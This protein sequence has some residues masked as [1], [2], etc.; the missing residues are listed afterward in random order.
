M[1]LP[2]RLPLARI[3]I[4]RTESQDWIHDVRRR[5]PLRLCEPERL[6]HL[7]KWPIVLHVTN[8]GRSKPLFCGETT[9][10]S[11]QSLW[12]NRERALPFA[13]NCVRR[14][15]VN[16]GKRQPYYP[17]PISICLELQATVLV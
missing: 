2:L 16:V 5:P 11:L 3:R 7:K 10:S 4:D 15:D 8:N 9:D 14:S 6:V 12:M 13:T 1:T 17:S